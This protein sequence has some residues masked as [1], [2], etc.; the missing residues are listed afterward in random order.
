M[1][2]GKCEY[3]KS[4]YVAVGCAEACSIG[5]SDILAR[6]SSAIAPGRFVLCVECYPGAFVSEIAAAIGDRLRPAVHIRAEE[7]FKPAAEI[8]RMQSP[9]LT[10]DRVFGK[11]NCLEILDFFDPVKLQRARDVIRAAGDGLIVVIGS[12]AT[13]VAETSDC[14]VYANMARWEI[15]QRQRRNEIGNLG[16]TTAHETAAAM[17]KRGFLVDWRAADRLKRGLYERID[18]L[19]DTNDA[20]TPKMISGADFRRGLD[21]VVRRPFRVAPFFDPGPN[22][23]KLPIQ[24]PRAQW[25]ANLSVP[26]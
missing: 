21:T 24:G 9:Y 14:L 16:F 17:Y 10:E 19:L 26:Q 23:Y 15:Q 12:G 4:P 22:P 8:E 7:C 3:D 11:T 6:L 5:W 18:F 1:L 25:I 13:L 20:R 2:T